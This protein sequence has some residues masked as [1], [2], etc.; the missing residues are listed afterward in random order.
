MTDESAL[1]AAPDIPELGAIVQIEGSD[2]ARR[3]GRLHGLGDELAGGFRQCGKDSTTVKPPDPRAKDGGPIKIPGFEHGPGFVRPIIENHRRP[4]AEAAIAVYGGH[5]GA[6]HAIVLKMLVERLNA[7]GPHAL[8]DQVSDGIIYHR[9]CHTRL[10]A[11]AIRQVGSAIELATT[12][13]NLAFGGLAER[14]NPRIEPVNKGAQ[15]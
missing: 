7:H 15:R 10:Q 1:V 8:R 2:G 14:N 5:I 11:K 4:H 6:V 9:G 13:V 3:L 12:N